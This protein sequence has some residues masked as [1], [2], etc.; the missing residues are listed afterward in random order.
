[1]CAAKMNFEGFKDLMHRVARS[2]LELAKRK[3]TDMDKILDYLADD[4]FTAKQT[5]NNEEAYEELMDVRMQLLV[6][7]FVRHNNEI[8]SRVF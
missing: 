3:V 7:N 8:S 4:P 5:S 2:W 1:M 6:G